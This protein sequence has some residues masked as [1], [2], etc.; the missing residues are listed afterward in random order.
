MSIVFLTRTNEIH[1]SEFKFSFGSFFTACGIII[2]PKFKNLIAFKGNMQ[3]IK[4]TAC[5]KYLLNKQHYIARN[6]KIKN[7]ST[8][9]L[10]KTSNRYWDYRNLS[11]RASDEN[12]KY[13]DK[14]TNKHL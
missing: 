5:K 13:Y 2:S 11:L 6:D 14:D 8:N 1:V 3:A 7:Q 10:I 9:F 12:N 4:C